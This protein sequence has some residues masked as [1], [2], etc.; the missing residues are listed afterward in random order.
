MEV[1]K[2]KK[3]HAHYEPDFK[4]EI[5]RMRIAA[6][7]NSGK[8]VDEIS[9]TF[10]I[11]RNVLHTWKNKSQMKT[12]TKTSEEQT[13]YSLNRNADRLI[14]ENELL[15]KEN[16]RLQSERDILKK[17]FGRRSCS[18]LQ[19]I[20]LRDI[21]GLIIS[22]SK[23]YSVEF[24]CSL[25]GVSRTAFYRY[26]RG[27]SHNS[28]KKYHRPKHEVRLEFL[29]YLKRYGSRRIKASLTKQGIKLSR[30]KVDDCVVSFIPM[31]DMN[32]KKMYF[33]TQQTRL[34]S[35]L[36]K[37]YTYFRE[38]DV[39]LAKVTPCFENGKSG[40]A[41]HLVNKTD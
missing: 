21:Y 13:A 1:N 37:G 12:K 2:T 33:E 41:R 11:G 17:S 28:D 14:S 35:E 5:L 36:H 39:L 7:L 24:L 6:Q 16:A 29:K 22:F 34:L 15:K 26:K 4:E 27:D 8:N 19:H 25:F 18:S 31:A 40:I 30:Q 20:Q 9:K 38:N 3:T 10:G 32:E 23:D